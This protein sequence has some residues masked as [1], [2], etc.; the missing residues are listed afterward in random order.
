MMGLPGLK[1]SASAS[2]FKRRGGRAGLT[3]DLRPPSTTAQPEHRTFVVWK[4]RPSAEGE[5][6]ALVARE[7]PLACT[8]GRPHLYVA[9]PKS[10][11]AR[12]A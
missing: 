1:G 7:G 2:P 8:R 6:K 12:P 5:E 4:S 9:Y 3:G 10:F 11:L